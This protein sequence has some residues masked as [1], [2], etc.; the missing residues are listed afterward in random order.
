MPIVKKPYSVNHHI[1]IKQPVFEKIETK[2]EHGFAFNANRINVMSVEVVMD[3]ANDQL[4]LNAG[5]CVILPG[6][7]GTAPWTKKVYVLDGQEFVLCPEVAI[8]GFT[9]ECFEV[10]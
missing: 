3:Y 9:T 7:A 10:K 2:T 6:D 4:R 8:L 1:A 5:D